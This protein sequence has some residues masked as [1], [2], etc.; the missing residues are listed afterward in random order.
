M[1][2]NIFDRYHEHAS[3]VHRLDPRSKLLV[4]LIF[5]LA[6][7]FLPD[8][9]WAAFILSWIL[10]AAT[11]IAAQIGIVEIT[12]KSV[13]ALPFAL[14]AITILFNQPGNP[15]VTFEKIAPWPLTITDAGVVRFFSI[16][17]RSWLSVQV[18]I[19]L[20]TTTR[21]PDI[22]HAMQHLRVPQILV[23]IISFMYRYM[24][25]LV[26]ETMRLLRARDSRSARLPDQ[27]GGGNISF[28]ARV[29][30]SM[31]GQLFL[32]S[33]ERSDRVYN[34]MV[35]RGYRGE[36]MTI[37]PHEMKRADW[38]L[39]SL[40]ICLILVIQLTAYI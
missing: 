6:T 34:A 19:L 25:V 12:K 33:Y 1:H 7:A 21:F 11:S 38:L 8:G 23:S 30:G 16:L 24:F 40:A 35:A 5:I 13:I 39:M 27:S 2:A 14:A 37:Y 9:S 36:L 10:I 28:R 20:V 32:R 3:L 22:I 18:A 4:V 29:A 17:I 31:A 15:V 26:D